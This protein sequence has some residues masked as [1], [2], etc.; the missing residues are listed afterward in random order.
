MM[1]YKINFNK[2]NLSR[3]KSIAILLLAALSVYQI[4]FLWF[5]NITNRNFLL[6]YI[7]FLRQVDIPE[8][9]EQ[10]TVP[11]RVIVPNVDGSFSVQ[12]NNLMDTGHIQYTHEVLARLHQDGRFLTSYP[13][14]LEEFVRLPAFIYEYTFP[15]EPEWFVHGF[16]ERSDILTN[17][18][19]VPFTHIA[20]MPYEEGSSIIFLCDNGFAHSF[21]VDM[22]IPATSIVEDLHL[23]TYIFGDG[24]FTRD[25][26]APTGVVYTNPYADPHGSF[27]INFIQTRV[28]N[29]F[30]NPIAIRP[31][32]GEDVWIY[33]S[34]NTVVRYYANE[35]LE[36]I[37]YL[38]IDR[39]VP[40]SFLHDFA[41]A[42]LFIKQDTLVT[43]EF[44]LHSFREHEGQHIFYFNFML[45]DIS[46]SSVS[47]NHPVIVTVDHGT[48]VRY[49]KL[50]RNFIRVYEGA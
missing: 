13:L 26:V 19:R 30:G 32:V 24:Q 43:N 20:I 28:S 38:A 46:L 21:F 7:P 14:S 6:N 8:G 47:I 41:A 27:S 11:W 1:D 40:T 17:R 18:V 23:P 34:A 29:F 12:Y 39:S 9:A 48:V 37:S 31:F 50:A 44:Y 3:I 36:Y 5:V 4:G 33:M 45:D 10:I 42:T 35:I 49:R 22:A 16:N 25:G 2:L 15:L